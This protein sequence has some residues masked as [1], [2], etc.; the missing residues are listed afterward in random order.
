[1]VVWLIV[2]VLS[3]SFVLLGREQVGL[4]EQHLGLVECRDRGAKHRS[5]IGQK[6]KRMS[7]QRRPT[8]YAGKRR[9]QE[10]KIERRNRA[11]RRRAQAT[12]EP[13]ISH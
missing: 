9:S 13:L 7:K 2:R 3:F 11:Y 8:K 6:E 12:D 1:M 5:V 10:P 4:C